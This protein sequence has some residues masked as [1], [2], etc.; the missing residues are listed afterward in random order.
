MKENLILEMKGISK[1]F[2]GVKALNQVDFD[3]RPGEIHALCG[4]NGAGKST[5]MKILAG[6]YAPTEG[7]IWIDGKEV[8]LSSCATA[9]ALGIAIVYQELSLSGTVTVA[10][11]IFMG[12]EPVGPFG[13]VRYK[14]M[15]QEAQKYLD[16]VQCPAKP[17][18]RVKLLPVAEMQMVQIAKALSS[19]ARILILDEPC[20]SI[21]EADSIRLFE[22]LD[23]LRKQGVAMIYI[24]HRLEN[25][26]R[27]ADRVTVFRDG[28][29][30]AT[31]DIG[32]TN[33][34]ELV[35]MMVGRKISN[36]YP[37]EETATNDIRLRVRGFTNRS[38]HDISFDLRK[39]EVLGLGGL[40][41]AGRS[42]VLRALFGIDKTETGRTIELDGQT[43]FI[44]RPSD[45]V[46]AGFGYVPED[47]KEAALCLRKSTVFNSVMVYLNY[48]M[49]K[50]FVDEKQSLS[51]TEDQIHQLKIKISD[52]QSNVEQLS[53]G[54]QQKVVIGRWLMMDD[55][56]VL[57]LDEPTRGIDVGAK[58]EIYKLI[59]S[60]AARGVSIIVVT[61]ELPELLGICDRILV[62]N[63]GRISGELKK[64]EFSQEGVMK[65]CV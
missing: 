18:D 3:L 2:P 46:K 50:L 29:K 40:V 51:K 30:I 49:K 34:D 6:N 9:E 12:R 11:N 32:Q 63:Q 28:E 13:L 53:G 36:I 42:E 26:Q 10:E 64:S 21:T 41:G 61:S 16:M 1:E 8:R 57:L 58:Y 22:I 15:N 19:H 5:L 60:L 56:K 25:I 35:Q 37:K 55:L 65:L 14:Q 33:A 44:Q 62:I 4:E 54:N 59:N 27:I 17:T 48:T 39:G 24:D 45:A 7:E 52:P 23:G 20:S 38:I 43:I 31:R 47:R